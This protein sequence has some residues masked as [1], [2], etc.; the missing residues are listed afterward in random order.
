MVFTVTW[1]LTPWLWAR[2]TALG[3]SDREKFPAKERIPKLVPARY[4]ASAP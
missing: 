1:T 3:S 2:A 4:T